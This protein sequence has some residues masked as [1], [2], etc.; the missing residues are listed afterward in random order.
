MVEALQNARTQLP[1]DFWAY[2]IMPARV[3]RSVY[4]R[5]LR[6]DRAMKSCRRLAGSEQSWTSCELA[7]PGCKPFHLPQHLQ[8]AFRG[9]TVICGPGCGLTGCDLYWVSMMKTCHGIPAILQNLR[10][11][12]DPVGN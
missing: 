12:A 3:H 4:S 9:K 7:L 11:N 6:S 1:F 10:Y 8:R 5:M 2:A